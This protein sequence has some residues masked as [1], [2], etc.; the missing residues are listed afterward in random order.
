MLL[1]QHTLVPPMQTVIEFALLFNLKF[2]KIATDFSRLHI[3]Y[4]K[5]LIPGVSIIFMQ[6][7]V[8]HFSK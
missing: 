8:I 3:Y 7:Q 6:R 5:P 1:S 4:P 2:R